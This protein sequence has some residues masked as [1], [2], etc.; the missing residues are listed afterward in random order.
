MR[1][2]EKHPSLAEHLF[3]D[4]RVRK[5]GMMILQHGVKGAA[6]KVNPAALYVDAALSVIEAVNS[7]LKYAKECEKT[8]QILAENRRIKS[9]LDGQLKILK[10]KQDTILKEGESRIDELNQQVQLNEQQRSN[11]LIEVK[12]HIQIAKVM[13]KKLKEER[14]SGINFK[15][16][17]EAQQALDHLLRASLMF[18][19]NNIE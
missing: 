16:L 6:K 12:K 4:N 8:K 13:Q 17:Q 7:Y 3:S 19:T 18:I 15:Q 5:Y 11:M 10:L 14:E 9:E 2:V 1:T